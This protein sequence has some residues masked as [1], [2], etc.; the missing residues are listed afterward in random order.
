MTF[1]ALVRPI[2]TLG[3]VAAQIALAVAWAMGLHAAEPAFAGLGAFTMLVVV[4]WFK[5]RS[6]AKARAERTGGR[7]EPPTG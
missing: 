6:E 4:Y 5:E 1:D 7:T 3:L 2:I